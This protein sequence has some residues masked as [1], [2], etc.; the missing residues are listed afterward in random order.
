[1]SALKLPE[2]V[3]AYF[4]TEIHDGRAVARCFTANAVV[5]DEGHVYVGLAEIERWKADAATRYSYTSEPFRSKQ[6]AGKI[7]VTSRLP[8]SPVDLRFFFGLEGGKI[9]SLEIIP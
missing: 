1:M 6:E 9:A 2:P 4:A 5:R 8:G 3:A 7:I